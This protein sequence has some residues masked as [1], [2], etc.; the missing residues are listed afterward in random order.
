MHRIATLILLAAALAGS[1]GPAHAQAAPDASEALLQQDK[2]VI[3]TDPAGWMEMTLDQTSFAAV[4]NV[5]VTYGDTVL[6]ADRALGWPVRNEIYVEGNVRVITPTYE[7]RCERAFIN[8]TTQEAVFEDFAVRSLDKTKPLAWYVQTPLGMRISDG[9]VI[10]KDARVTTCDYDIPHQYLRVR[11]IVIKKNNDIIVKH[12]TF[13][14]WGV[15][16]PLYLPHMILP[17]GRPSFTGSIGSSS[18]RGFY[19]TLDT[20]VD[21]PLPLNSRGTLKLGYFSK[22]GP[23]YGLQLDYHD[24]LIA[25][26]LAEFYTLP[27]DLGRDTDEQ[28]LGTTYRH[29]YRWIHSMDSPEGWEVDVE[30]QKYSDA[31]FQR[32]FFENEYY[33]EKTPEGRAYLK[34][35]HENW[36][37][38]MEGK[39]RLNDY[40]DETEHLPVAGL[41]GFSQPLFAGLL[42]T[43]DTQF[44]FL[45]RRLSEIRRR[46][47]DTNDTYLARRYER[48]AFQ[49]LPPIALD[50]YRG[51]DRTV[52]RID[53]MQEIS[54]PFALNRLKVE[55]FAGVRNTFYDKTLDEDESIWRNQ[56]FYGIR[57]STS[58]HRFYDVDSSFLN[59]D[60]LRH[61]ITPDVAYIARTETWGVDRHE[62]IQL[63]ERDAAKQEDRI[64]MRLRNQFQTRRNGRIVDVLDL[65]LEADHYPHSDRDYDGE[66][67]SPLRAGARLRPME[68]LLIFMNADLDFSQRDKGLAFYN[69][70]SSIDLSDRWS[71]TI[72]HTYERDIDSYGRYSVAYLLTPKWTASFSY[73]RNWD[74]G[75]SLEERVT[76][77]RDFQDFDLSIVFRNDNRKDETT[78][79]VNISPK[80]LRMPPK[81]SS[82]VRKLSEARD[83]TE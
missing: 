29:R 23:A 72:G 81:A 4:G 71:A 62:L 36:A 54:M 78:V 1:A 47:D 12:V 14:V 67:F 25:R 18:S 19:T 63:D 68:G 9:T 48:N 60:G 41:R 22:R 56:L 40:L 17:E 34:Y 43:S 3:A 83:D 42:W 26:G 8:W 58:L 37:A 69:L 57:T 49:D 65:D 74:T 11:E 66:S 31:G 39:I 44:G 20:S 55:P 53:S 2:M 50:E 73:D 24:P 35:S 7:Y 16:M 51:D 64:A 77:T 70:G 6:T 13:H 80:A 28:E 52:F 15:P 30:L 79:T 45:R 21:L 75:K 76:L 82:F 5:R 61:I 10:A 33:N 27:H 38:Y 32:E 59:I 46:P